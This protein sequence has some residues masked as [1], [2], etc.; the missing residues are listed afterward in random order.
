MQAVVDG[1]LR[2]LDVVNR[3]STELYEKAIHSLWSIIS[4][5]FDIS[6]DTINNYYQIDPKNMKFH[7]SEEQREF[8]PNILIGNKTEWVSENHIGDD[9]KHI[10]LSFLAYVKFLI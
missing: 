4:Y 7:E 3:K 8:L 1:R 2:N 10:S 6:P 5:T 9:C